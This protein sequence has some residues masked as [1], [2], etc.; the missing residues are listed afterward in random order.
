[1]DLAWPDF[2]RPGDAIAVISTAR[3]VT[4]LEL[5]PFFAAIK[6]RGYVPVQGPHLYAQHHQWAGTDAERLSD[7]QWAMNDPTIKA[8]W[9]ARG[10][11]GSSR[12]LDAVDWSPL[13]AAP[14]WIIGFSD[15]TAIHAALY[16]R[17]IAS[18][19]GPMGL[20]F[21]PAA[22]VSRASLDSAF[23]ILS[24]ELPQYEFTH[25]AP[26][27]LQHGLARGRLIGGNLSL[28]VHLLGTPD[29]LPLDGNLLVLEDLDEYRYHIDRMLVQLRRTGAFERISGLVVG[30]FTHLK[31]KPENPFG[32]DALD[33]IAQH[34]AAYS[35]V[36]ATG[37]PFG[38]GAENHA[39][40]HGALAELEVTPS[41]VR[42]STLGASAV[43]IA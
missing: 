35:C 16:R 43:A 25:R 3:K 6:A 39:F 10:G 7:L 5:E 32:S 18:I 33:M 31:D 15:V 1:M 23:N 37:F 21:I 12:L 36:V 14:K 20:S 2:L 34:T 30:S 27:A 24:G 8:I 13:I 28:L 17:G 40:V 11:Y 9:C 41:G 26:T 38:H 19:H 22:G 42:L 29:A 4:P